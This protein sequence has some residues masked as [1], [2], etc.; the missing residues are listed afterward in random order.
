LTCSFFEK[1]L[2]SFRNF[3]ILLL[4][5]KGSVL[6][7][8]FLKPGGEVG[9]GSDLEFPAF[10][11]TVEEE[12]PLPTPAIAPA[13]SR[14]WSG[15]GG[16]GSSNASRRRSWKGK[17]DNN[18]EEEEEEEVTEGHRLAL[19]LQTIS[20]TFV[21]ARIP[22]TPRFEVHN[23]R[24][25]T[26]E[27]PPLPSR[28][29]RSVEDVL[30]ILLGEVEETGDDDEEELFEQM[31]EGR[32]GKD[33]QEDISYENG[34]ERGTTQ[35]KITLITPV[36]RRLGLAGGGLRRSLPIHSKPSTFFPPTASLQTTTSTRRDHFTPT[37]SSNPFT[38]NRRGDDEEDVEV[39]ESSQY[40]L[41]LSQR[42][43]AIDKSHEV[44]EENEDSPVESWEVPK[45]SSPKPPAI[46]A[47][48]SNDGNRAGMTL[49]DED[50]S[51][52]AGIEDEAFCPSRPTASTSLPTPLARPLSG[53]TRANRPA[54]SVPAY[55]TP[56]SSSHSSL[57]PLNAKT[58][59][60]PPAMKK[61]KPVAQQKQDRIDKWLHKRAATEEDEPEEDSILSTL[62]GISD[63]NST[64]SKVIQSEKRR[65]LLY[66]E[67]NGLSNPSRTVTTGNIG[68]VFTKGRLAEWSSCL[69]FPGDKV[70]NSLIEKLGTPP[71]RTKIIPNRFTDLQSYRYSF[72]D[73]IL[74]ELQLELLQLAIR[75]R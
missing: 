35:P 39:K 52:F 21:S 5:E 17:R 13:L 6:D 46:R 2:I 74:E 67:K 10:L 19:R 60:K 28:S 75:F 34:Q 73:A 7:S 66:G 43:A 44:E 1:L 23:K 71:Q 51:F 62:A 47:L 22:P 33:M 20:P 31:V 8:Q 56:S 32:E 55:K 58:P 26:K 25:K 48:H 40:R 3:K 4:D 54:V 64:V 11:V 65:R 68:E 61:E 72:I 41:S 69:L 57:A 30:S 27:S 16:A 14:G 63:R 38:R 18:E 59:W 45:I 12:T 24:Q 49:D 29:A 37:L 15:A 42:L 36:R 50:D 53:F 70:A 9:S